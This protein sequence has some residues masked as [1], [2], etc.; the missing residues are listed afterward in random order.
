MSFKEMLK[1]RH[2]LNTK[3]PCMSWWRSAFNEINNWVFKRGAREGGNF[4]NE[5]YKYC[6]NMWHLS[7]SIFFIL[8]KECWHFYFIQNPVGTI[9]YNT[10]R[11]KK[12]CVVLLFWSPKIFWSIYEIAMV[13]CRSYRIWSEFSLGSDFLSISKSFPMQNVILEWVCESY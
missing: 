13:V 10:W 12:V 11:K 7:G 1:L 3:P 9:F 6:V 2:L 4:K 5:Q 8:V